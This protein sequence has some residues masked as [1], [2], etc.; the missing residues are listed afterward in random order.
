MSPHISHA[1][2]P[3]APLHRRIRRAKKH[4]DELEGKLFWK[5]ND[6]AYTVLTKQDGPP[7]QYVGEIVHDLHSA[8]DHVVCIL[9]RITKSRDDC[10]VLEFPFSRTKLGPGEK[11]QRMGGTPDTA[12]AI[13]ERYQPHTMKAGPPE[14]HPLWQLH[15]LSNRDKHRELAFLGGLTI[16][17]YDAG[18]A[19]QPSSWGIHAVELSDLVPTVTTFPDG[20]RRTAYTVPPPEVSVETKPP[21]VYITF[22]EPADLKGIDVLLS[23]LRMLRTVA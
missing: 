17:E 16:S 18:P 11:R 1:V 10:S 20:T 4:F 15:V 12:R 23:V 5:S 9:S 14:R 13:I 21:T 22:E 7:G 6:K 3:C 2:Y 8:L 19:G